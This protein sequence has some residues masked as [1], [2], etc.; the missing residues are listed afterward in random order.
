MLL[1]ILLRI[2]RCWNLTWCFDIIWE[3]PG[4]QVFQ[5]VS[6]HSFPQ[7]HVQSHLPLRTLTLARCCKMSRA[8]VCSVRSRGHFRHTV[9]VEQVH[10]WL[11][12]NTWGFSL[13][14][15]SNISGNVFALLPFFM[16]S[17]HR[18]NCAHAISLLAHV[19]CACVATAHKWA[20]TSFTAAR[21]KS[22][23]LRYQAGAA[24]TYLVLLGTITSKSSREFQA[25]FESR[26][27]CTIDTIAILC[28]EK[29]KVILFF[30]PQCAGLNE[31]TWC[32]LMHF[33][34]SFKHL[35]WLLTQKVCVYVCM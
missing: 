13:I 8:N 23:T 26:H 3:A 19:M 12:S 2:S 11:L 17:N 6:W 28:V 18:L 1:Y 33:V 7:D 9:Q 30:F 35:L 32:V 15:M 5:E 22:K 10:F 24:M 29:I 21:F 34:S 31:D 25:H 16:H 14:L 27:H 20:T 4:V